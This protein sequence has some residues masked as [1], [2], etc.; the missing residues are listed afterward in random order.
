VAKHQREEEGEYNMGS[1]RHHVRL[2]GGRSVQALLVYALL[3][4]DRAFQGVWRH[5][6]VDGA[7]THKSFDSIQS[8]RYVLLMTA[9]ML[10]YAAQRAGTPLP[11]IGRGIGMAFGLWALVIMQSICQHQVSKTPHVIS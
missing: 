8:R 1:Q 2:L 6:S 7:F 10:V 3:T 5:C 11:N 4:Y 9:L